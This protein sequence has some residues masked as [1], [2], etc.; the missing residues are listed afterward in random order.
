MFHRHDKE[1]ETGGGDAAQADNTGAAEDAEGAAVGRGGARRPVKE[2]LS[3]TTPPVSSQAVLAQ[4]PETQARMTELESL[5]FAM[6]RRQQE[7][8]LALSASEVCA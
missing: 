6:A 2:P 7:L 8:A 1:D 5:I 4:D 3:P